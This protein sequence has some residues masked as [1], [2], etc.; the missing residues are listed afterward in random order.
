MVDL[1][2]A[3]RMAIVRSMRDAM[4]RAKYAQ[5]QRSW[6]DGYPGPAAMTAALLDTTTEEVARVVAGAEQ[7]TES[8][9]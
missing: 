1:T 7:H 4:I 6:G 2:F 9:E 3:G 5:V 8:P